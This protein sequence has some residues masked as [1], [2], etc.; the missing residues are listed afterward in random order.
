MTPFA[1][2]KYNGIGPGPVR[3]A[4]YGEIHRKCHFSD[5]L[6]DSAK[7]TALA[8]ERFWL[9]NGDFQYVGGADPETADIL[10]TWRLIDLFAVKKIF[11]EQIAFATL[12][13]K[14]TIYMLRSG[15]VLSGPVRSC[16]GRIT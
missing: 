16:T 3:E 13:K 6:R 1:P 4:Q 9:K 12:Y 2:I 11:F 7:S 5:R 8:R 10:G 14:N 15:P